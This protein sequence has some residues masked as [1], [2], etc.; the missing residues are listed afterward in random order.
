MI[1]DHVPGRISR[2]ST[3]LRLAGD[4]D[5][6]PA[7]VAGLDRDLDLAAGDGCDQLAL[8]GGAVCHARPGR[9]PVHLIRHRGKSASPG[10]A[11]PS[12]APRPAIA[13]RAIACYE[14]RPRRDRSDP[15]PRRERQAH[16]RVRGLG[17]RRQDHDRRGARPGRGAARPAGP[18][19]SRS[20]RPGAWPTRSASTGSATRSAWS[21]PAVV[22][23]RRDPAAAAARRAPRD[24]ARPEEGVR[25][26]R[27]RAT[28]ATRPRSA[29]SSATRST[30]RSRARWPAPT[31]TPRW[32]SCRSSTPPAPGT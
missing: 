29:A 19:S 7:V 14:S 22:V 25:R 8:H 12:R 1:S 17:W 13:P 23:G 20:T 5:A 3:A 2:A 31:S 26:G 28:P 4:A 9:R 16:P 18:W 6:P 30:A 11:R 15:R 10:P 32:P 24:D 27:R 21:I